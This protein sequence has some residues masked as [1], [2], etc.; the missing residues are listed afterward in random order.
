MTTAPTPVCR[1]FAVFVAAA[2]RSCGSAN[3]CPVT[4]LDLHSQATGAG[5]LLSQPERVCGL[6][7]AAPAG[8]LVRQ[9]SLDN[10]LQPTS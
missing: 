6:L 1:C 8:S 9:Q 5:N 4:R 2:W 3:E 7:P 10:K